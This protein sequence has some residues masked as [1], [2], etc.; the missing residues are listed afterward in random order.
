MVGVHVIGLLAVGLLLIPAMRDDSELPP[1]GGDSGND[2]GWGNRPR[3]PRP[4][5]NVP[6]GGLPLPDALPAR[7]RLRDG[8]RLHERLPGRERRPAREPDRQP[9]RTPTHNQ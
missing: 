8:R 6:G 3:T 9:I 1:Q 7:V 5:S 4:P 2:D